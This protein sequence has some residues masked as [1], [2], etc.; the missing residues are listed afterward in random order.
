M[1]EVEYGSSNGLDGNTAIL[2]EH[3]ILAARDSRERRKRELATVEVR[4]KV[5]PD[6]LDVQLQWV[7]EKEAR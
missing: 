4:E 3:L 7:K 2:D 5:L 6:L 1:E